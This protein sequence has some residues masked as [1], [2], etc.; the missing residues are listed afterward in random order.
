MR[1]WESQVVLWSVYVQLSKKLKRDNLSLP[2]IL[3]DLVIFP[4]VLSQL[5]FKPQ[6]PVG[7][8]RSSNST[9]QQGRGSSKRLLLL[10]FLLWLVV[11]VQSLSYGKNYANTRTIHCSNTQKKSRRKVEEN[12]ISSF[13]S[14]L[15]VSRILMARFEVASG[16]HCVPKTLTYWELGVQ[17]SPRLMVLESKKIGIMVLLHKTE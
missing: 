1:G 3:G 2:Q 5:M 7:Q 10:L 9:S 13:K 11:R 15:N 17:Q 8:K 16:W 12:W 4:T 6:L 14:M